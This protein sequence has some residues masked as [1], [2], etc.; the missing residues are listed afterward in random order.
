MPGISAFNGFTKETVDFFTQLKKNNNKVWF[1]EHK[2]DY[3]THVMTPSREFVVAMGEHLEK[4]SPGIHADPR[5]NKS[6]FRIYRD[7]RFSKDKTL[8]KAHLAMWWWEGDGPR[9]ECSGYYFHL[10]PPNLMLGVG[11]YMF[12]KGMMQT[13]RD[14]VVDSIYGAALKDAINDVSKQDK[15]SL[16]GKN[17]KRVPR[18]YDP[19]HENV[20]LLLYNGMHVGYETRIPEVFYSASLVDYCFGVYQDLYPIQKWLVEMIDR[21]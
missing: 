17:Y 18:G 2:P 15:Y 19:E 7:T 4:L 14:S 3:D 13:Y 6:I 12:P 9:M 10:E 5:V 8:Y 16:G 1:D 21:A 11:I 20:E